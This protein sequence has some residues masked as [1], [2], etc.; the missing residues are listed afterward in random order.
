MKKWILLILPLLLL[1]GSLAADDAQ[2]NL[3]AASSA[4]RE[5]GKPYYKITHAS[6]LT[7]NNPDLG[8][9]PF[10]AYRII[11]TG[12]PLKA[13]PVGEADAAIKQRLNIP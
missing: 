3:D 2:K 5:M 7:V 13:L 9:T 8:G 10:T 11:L 4:I 1:T 6:R 12:T